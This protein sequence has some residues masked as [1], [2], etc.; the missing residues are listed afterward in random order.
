MEISDHALIRYI[1]RVKGVSL[2]GYRAELAQM[3]AAPAR[4]ATKKD[5]PIRPHQ[6]GL[7]MQGD[8]IVTILTQGMR[9]KGGQHALDRRVI[10]GEVQRSVFSRIRHILGLTHDR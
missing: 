3:L 10:V 6:V 2:E 9:P 8:R 1:E 5:G 4:E 7:V